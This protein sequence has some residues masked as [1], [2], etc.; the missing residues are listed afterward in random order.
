[1]MGSHTPLARMPPKAFLDNHGP[2]WPLALRTE[3]QR[4][5]LVTPWEETA[6]DFR[7]ITKRPLDKEALDACIEVGFGHPQVILFRGGN[8][9]LCFPDARFHLL[10][11]LGC[12][13]A[14][15]NIGGSVE[16]MYSGK[17]G[18]VHGVLTSAM[19]QLIGLLEKVFKGR[20]ESG[21][22]GGDRGKQPRPGDEIFLNVAPMPEE[23]SSPI[24]RV[25]PENWQRLNVM[26]GTATPSDRGPHD[27]LG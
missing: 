12:L 25:T 4:K 16:R 19:G 5:Q 17:I 13:T 18:K 6:D 3:W 20:T 27:P 9:E 22:E 8:E 21:E 26:V 15:Q 7:D 10:H 24:L 1:M 23:K 14:K 11:T 2:A